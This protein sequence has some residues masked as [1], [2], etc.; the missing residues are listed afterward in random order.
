MTLPAA[1]SEGAVGR[2]SAPLVATAGTYGGGSSSISADGRFVAFDSYASDLV[3]DDN[4]R[5]WDV[6]VR[7]TVAGTTRRVSVS[8]GGLQGNGPSH[9]PAISADGRFVAFWS[10]ASNLVA[11]DTN[12]AWDVFARDLQTN[13]TTRASLTNAGAQSAGDSVSGERVAISGD[14]RFV[15][16]RSA[17]S[18]L[19]TGDTNAL[20]DIFVRD[21]VGGTTKRV[22]VSSAGTQSNGISQMPDISADGQV[23]AFQ[24]YGANL[25]PND[26][27]GTS[28]VFAR[29]LATNLTARVSVA[30]NGAEG[31]AYSGSPS[32]SATGNRVAFESYAS[33]LVP[34]DLY[35]TAD[36]FVR[37]TAAGTTQWVTVAADGT[38]ADGRSGLARISGDGRFVAF[39]SFAANLVTDGEDAVWSVYE[40]DLAAGKTIRAGLPPA[41]DGTSFVSDLPAVSADGRF[42]TFQSPG[43]VTVGDA[44]VSRYDVF[45][46]DT[47]IRAVPAYTVDDVVSALRIAGGFAA[48]APTDI[49]RLHIGGDTAAGVG[50][51]DALAMA[52]KVNGLDAN[53]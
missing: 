16:F 28:D 21:I 44:A 32:L 42:V 14:G 4:N 49:A 11:G 10:K 38:R 15:A 37:D 39:V 45:L 18:T 9:H 26:T 5:T 52:R 17:A 36:I 3:A 20:P 48:A 31:N 40:R 12:N 30:A 47:S 23:V 50:L 35:Q 6:F 7:D 2:I 25:V 27:N 19:V 43:L 13:T 22:S 29:N 41:E 53:H 1:A 46:R 8:G 33:N 24:S 34:G 51:E